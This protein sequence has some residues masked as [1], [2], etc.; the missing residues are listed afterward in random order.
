MIGGGI[1]GLA[2]AY[3]VRRSLPRVELRLFEARD[4]LGG[5]LYTLISGDIVLEQGADS[6]LIK[7]P[8]ALDLCRELGL[9][10]RLVPTGEKFRRALVVRAGRLVPVPE[11]FILM[12]PQNLRVILQSPILSAAGKLRLM[13][14]RVAPV[15]RAAHQADYDESVASFAIRRL[16]R[17]VYE[18]LVEPLVAGIYVADAHKLS[19]A[20]TFPEFLAAERTHGSLLAATR[21]TRLAARRQASVSNGQSAPP[22]AS[23]ARY[24]QFVTLRGGLKVLVDALTRSLPASA[25]RL[26][27]PVNRIE[28]RPSGRWTVTPAGGE[29]PE[30]FDGVILAASAQQAAQ[31]VSPWDDEL[32]H[33]LAQI[34]YASSTVTTLV[35]R[36]DQIAHPLDGFGAVVPAVERRPIIAASFLHVKL[37][38][39][40]PKGLAVIRVFAGGVLHPETIDLDDRQLIATAKQQLA[41]LVGAGGEPL[42]IHVARW[43][44]SMPQYH[45]GHLQLI[46]AIDQGVRKYPGLQLTGSGYRGV[47]IPQCIRSARDA[48]TRMAEALSASRQP[49]Q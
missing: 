14:E 40:V 29:P 28:L 25:V 19:L 43:R 21:A 5:P 34:E 11:G 12:N 8:Y 18:R 13:A 3:Y 9:A 24:G 44:H 15:P 6:F 17:E 41:E 16:G 45:V 22:A 46:D 10:D 23:T 48:A 39:H 7:T 33:R 47:G 20:A 26:M 2:A 35:Y 32:A 30:H 49:K 4:R 38:T 37:P 27:T 1:S 42:E 36:R 31:L